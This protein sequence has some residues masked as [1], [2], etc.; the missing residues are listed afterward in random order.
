MVFRQ[1]GTVLLAALVCAASC[2]GSPGETVAEPKPVNEDSLRHVSQ[3]DSLMQRLSVKEKVAQLFIIEISRFPDKNTKEFHKM[4]VENYGIGSLIL[5]KGPV[6]QFIDHVNQLQ[7]ASDIPLLVAV[8]AEWGAAMRFPEY[9]PYPRQALLG[10][11]ENRA[12]L[13]YQMGRNVGRELKDLNILINLAP[14]A[15]VCADPYNK[16]ESQRSFGGDPDLVAEYASAYMKGMQDEGIYACGKHYPGI[17][18]SYVDSHYAL[19]VIRHSREHLD[20]VDLYPYR[21][22]IEE[23]MEMV[24]IGHFC[25]PDIDSTG[26]PMSISRECIDQVLK[27]DQKFNGVVITDALPMKGIARGKTALK[28]NL[29]VYRGGADMILMPSDVIKTIDAIADSVST[30]AF[31]IEELDAKVRKVL[32]LKAR[33][34]Y[35][36]EGFSAQVTDLDRKISEALTRDTAL[37][38]K[39]EKAMEESSKPKIRAW[40][41][42]RTLLLDRK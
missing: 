34:G 10:R 23:G 21:R 7:A 24:M 29:A 33:A 40:G 2:T 9:C 41:R 14:V 3:V 17:G 30:G 31:P 42:D 19:P 36:D 11:M 15:D 13:M 4:L 6:K 12:D 27:K 35:F 39:M 26:V 20:T 32:D 1:I 16:A 22:L 18:D 28:A 38:F 8:D 5:M 37:V 25:I